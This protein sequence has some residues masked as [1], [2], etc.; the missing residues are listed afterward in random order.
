MGLP[1]AAAI[2]QNHVVL[3]SQSTGDMLIDHMLSRRFTYS[4]RS[5]KTICQCIHVSCVAALLN[6]KQ[7]QFSCAIVAAMAS[8]GGELK[9]VVRH[10]RALQTRLRRRA[11]LELGKEEGFS[12]PPEHVVL[13]VQPSATCVLAVFELSG[14][15]SACA[16]RFLAAKN[17]LNVGETS[18]LT[19]LASAI[20]DAYLQAPFETIVGLLE[21]PACRRHRRDLFAAGRFIVERQ[22]YAWLLTQNRKGVAPGRQ[23]LVAE[24]CKLTPKDLPND[25][26]SMLEQYWTGNGRARSQRKWLRRFRFEY[27]LRLG[28]VRVQAVMPLADMQRKAGESDCLGWLEEVWVIILRVKHFKRDFLF[29]FEGPFL[30]PSG[31]TVFGPPSCAQYRVHFMTP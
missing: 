23:Q 3:V 20:E 29:H 1:G 11:R 10:V 27:G 31:G 7:R 26:A 8:L 14:R 25:V 12:D 9:S 19:S 2:L 30:D 17:K 15:N 24:A 21:S 13:K 28:R 6:V 5:F 4:L 16:A 18:L 22:L